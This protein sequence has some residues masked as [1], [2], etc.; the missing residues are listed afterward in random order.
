M[1]KIISLARS[2][3]SQRICC[4]F[5]PALRFLSQKWSQMGTTFFSRQVCAGP[6]VNRK[7]FLLAP[8]STKRRKINS[9]CTFGKY[10]TYTDRAVHTR[11]AFNNYAHACT[12]LMMLA[13]A[14]QRSEHVH[15][16]CQSR[17]STNHFPLSTSS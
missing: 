2:G 10:S 12:E 4:T 13:Q 3:F 17:T 16:E 5:K 14:E 15:E 7:I 6:F 1:S 8:E 9:F 11:R